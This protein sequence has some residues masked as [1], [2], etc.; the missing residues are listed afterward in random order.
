MVVSPE[1]AKNALRGEIN[2]HALKLSPK[3]ARVAVASLGGRQSLHK[4]TKPSAAADLVLPLKGELSGL[5]VEEPRSLV[6]LALYRLLRS[7]KHRL[8]GERWRVTK[9]N[10]K[11]Y[12]NI[13]K[14]RT[15]KEIIQYSPI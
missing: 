1:G 15:P 12:V 5:A 11:G 10:N 14:F 13:K 2:R 9:L 6:Q 8:Q 7:R 3:Y 4:L